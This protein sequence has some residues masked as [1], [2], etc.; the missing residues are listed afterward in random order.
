M[1]LTRSPCLQI[2][3]NSGHRSHACN[4]PHWVH[5]RVPQCLCY[6]GVLEY[7]SELRGRLRAG[8]HLPVGSE[9]EVEIRGCSIAAVER[10]RRQMSAC[11]PK[12]KHITSAQID[13]YLWNFAKTHSNEMEGYPIHRT[14]TVFY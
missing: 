3:G 8:Q 11:T 4:H 5:F 10:I 6:L 14:L 13:F 2:T 7:S 1:T 12:A 9:E